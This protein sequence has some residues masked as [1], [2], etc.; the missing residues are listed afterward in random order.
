MMV[1]PGVDSYTRNKIQLKIHRK[2]Q[3]DD[4]LLK[5]NWNNSKSET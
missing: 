5:P 4:N 3:Q 2:T 1:N